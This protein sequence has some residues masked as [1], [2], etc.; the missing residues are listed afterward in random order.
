METSALR[1]SFCCSCCS[2][3]K[4]SFRSY[5]GRIGPYPARKGLG[6]RNPWH[7]KRCSSHRT[8]PDALREPGLMA[9]TVQL[10][11]R[12]TS[13]LKWCR[14]LCVSSYCWCFQTC[15]TRLP[16][17][18][19]NAEAVCRLHRRSLAFGLVER[20]LSEGLGQTA[21]QPGFSAAVTNL[22]LHHVA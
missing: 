20:A 8:H 5:C 1:V 12:S 10:P 7:D 21:A 4:D 11:G 22:P 18:L 16:R 6:Y 14:E 9:T 13:G 19:S 15:R 3:T 17:K 2:P